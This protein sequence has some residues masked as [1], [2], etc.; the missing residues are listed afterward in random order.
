MILPILIR[1]SE[2]AL[3][4]VPVELRQG[5]AALGLSRWTTLLRIELPAAVPGIV[6]GLVLGIGRALAE[7]AAL[8]FT[9]GT[10]TRQPQSVFDSGRS[11]SI[12]IYEMAMH[13]PGG[14][15]RACATAI[16]L[17]GVLIMA[18]VVVG[19]LVRR[20]RHNQPVQISIRGL[21]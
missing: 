13:V 20:R 16:V 4:S 11:L 19:R 7:T 15:S 17:I 8:I 3:R 18:N 1:T 14:G 5:A 9:A 21:S 12:H 10:V 2:E 6:A